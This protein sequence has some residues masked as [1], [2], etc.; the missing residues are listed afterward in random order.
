MVT[1]NVFGKL[2]E[3][4]NYSIHMWKNVCHP[5]DSPWQQSQATPVVIMCW[6]FEQK[7]STHHVFVSFQYCGVVVTV[8]GKGYWK[9]KITETSVNFPPEHS[10]PPYCHGTHPKVDTHKADVRV[11]FFCVVLLLVHAV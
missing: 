10:I 4:I 11:F 9:K 2:F 6:D 8:S 3:K 5:T 7:T 1:G